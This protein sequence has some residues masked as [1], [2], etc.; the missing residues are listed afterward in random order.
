MKNVAKSSKHFLKYFNTLETHSDYTYV[1]TLVIR[2][3]LSF[4]VK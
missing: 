4:T 3:Y 2:Y 1:I